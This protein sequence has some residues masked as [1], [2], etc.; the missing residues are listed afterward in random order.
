MSSV[1]RSLVGNESIVF[2]AGKHPMAPIRASAPA[3][4]MVLVGLMLWL[5]NPRPEGILT[6]V[7]S[8]LALVR[9]VLLIGGAAWIAANI[10]AWRTTAFAV[11]TQRV[12]RHE[13]LVRRHTSGTLL[14]AIVDAKLNLGFLGKVMGYADVVLI[15]GPGDGVADTL[16]CVADATEFR[17]ALMSAKV[18]DRMAGRA[19][20]PSTAGQAPAHGPAQAGSLADAPTPALA[21]VPSALIGAPASAPAGMA[22]PSSAPPGAATATRP[23]PSAA[24]DQAAR[25]MKLAELCDR[26]LISPEEF[27]AKKAE[28]LARM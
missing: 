13:G 17:H 23:S 7:G 11:T 25:L 16:A 5:W 1:A 19:A 12:L 28:I 8:I 4:A 18:A 21:P 27:Q 6:V 10:V 26:G 3:V 9:W 14:S 20:M 22:P 15:T 24:G 2:E